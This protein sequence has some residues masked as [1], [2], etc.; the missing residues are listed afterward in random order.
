MPE[1]TK[2]QTLDRTNDLVYNCTTN[3]VKAIMSLSHGV[4]KSM[5]NEYLNLVKAVGIELRELLG[6]VDKLSAHFPPQ[7]HK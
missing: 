3:V 5:L 2:T 4:E 6:T 1:Q 7:T